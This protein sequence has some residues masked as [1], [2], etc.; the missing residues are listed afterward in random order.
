MIRGIF[1]KLSLNSKIRLNNDVE[2]PRFGLGTWKTKGKDAIN[3]VKWAIEAGYIHIDTASLYGNEKEIGQ[4]I[5]ESKIRREDIFITSKVWDSDQGFDPT[6][7]ALDISLKKLGTSYVDLYLIHWPRKQK[8]KETWTALEKIN[9][10]E[11]ARAIGV[12][13]YWIHHI[14]EILENFEIIP[15]VNQF[16]LSPYLYREELINF[17]RENNIAIEAYSPLTHGK[18]LNNPKLRNIAKKY[19]KSTAQILIRWGLQ[20]V[21]IEIPKSTQKEH[22]IQNAD[23]FDFQLREEDM[24]ALNEIEENYQLLYDTSKWD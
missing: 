19:N 7:K 1:L 15:A 11:K 17:C 14:Q 20:H 13:N 23:V 10:D 12:A 21:F 16:E 4:A 8:R 5:K 24:I 6:L 3:A 18:K 9:K 2:M 22:I